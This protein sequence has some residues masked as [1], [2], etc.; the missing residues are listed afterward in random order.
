M[1]LPKGAVKEL[2]RI[3]KKDEAI[4]SEWFNLRPVLG[5]ANWALIFILLGGREAGKS[6]SVTN[7]FVDQYVNR[8]I[9]FYWIRLTDASQSKLLTN[10]A[11]KLIDPDLRRKYNLDIYTKGDTVFRVLKRGKEKEDGSPGK[12]VKSEMMCRVLALSTFYND[13][14]S[15]L[16]DKDFLKDENMR[17]NICLDEMNR[18]KNERNTFDITYAFVNEI[19]NLI[20]STKERVKIFCIG[21]TLEEASDLLCSLNFIPEKFGTFKLKSKRTV[22]QYIEPSQAYL[23]RRKGTIADI[24]MPTASTFTNKID[25]DT[26]LVTK[27]KLISPSHLI[28]F[29]KNKRDWFCVWNRN[30]I[31]KYNGEKKRA[32]AMRPYL[33]EVYAADEVK[34]VFELFDS[35]SYKFRNLITFKE[36]QKQLELLKPRS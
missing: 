15:G 26:A 19:E 31:A 17:Y 29:S 32:I 5:M 30:I 36:F 11:E 23:K 21:N 25:T 1:K 8:H 12:I 2:N 6:Y 7:F 14:G 22:I 35:R 18:E 28:K 10:N 33:D 27:E 3:A 16:F 9:P 13:K 34:N 24:L 4:K 20:R